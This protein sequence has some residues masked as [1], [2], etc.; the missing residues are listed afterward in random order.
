MPSNFFI[1]GTDTE[2]GKTYLSV[3]LL[4]AFNALGYSTIGIKP[5]ASGAIYQGTH[6]VNDD[7]LQLQK[8]SSIQLHY[9]DI[10][11]FV[12]ESPIA[13]HIAAQRTNAHLT[14]EGVIA[15]IKPALDYPA[16]IHLLEGAGGWNTPLNHFE[17]MADFVL[18]CDLSVILV[19]GLKLGCINHAI[20]SSQAIKNK[21]LKFCG[22]I[23]NGLQS[24]YSETDEIIATLKKMMDAP[25][26][27]MVGHGE[28]LSEMVAMNVLGLERL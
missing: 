8:A 13:P 17:T 3:G 9:K 14:V 21:N 26:L 2:I 6:L 20:L 16:D 12:F 15:K 19:V 7:A 25:Y 24:N 5:I 22:W 18:R 27:G 10:N 23:G 1:T 11:P 4:T 28:T